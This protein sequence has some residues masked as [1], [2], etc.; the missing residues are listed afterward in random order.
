M[1]IKKSLRKHS[2]LDSFKI[3]KISCNYG[4]IQLT[5]V[6]I[7]GNLQYILSFLDFFFVVGLKITFCVT[8]KTHVG[9][10]LGVK[11]SF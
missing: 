11:D 7:T 2:F 10:I 8:K 5:R 4:K 1:L 9:G 3:C 6:L